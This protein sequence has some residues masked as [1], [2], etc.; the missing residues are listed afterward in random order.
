MLKTLMGSAIATT[1]LATLAI[2]APVQAQ[3]FEPYPVDGCPGIII[4]Y[5][6]HDR[7]DGNPSLYSI[8]S[9]YQGRIGLGGVRLGVNSNIFFA[10]DLETEQIVGYVYVNDDARMIPNPS[11]MPNINNP[12]LMRQLVPETV[13]ILNELVLY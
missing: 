9:G 2:A 7:I 11:G 3:S 10:I 6:C 5:I 13:A 8:P 12:R 4:N 1:F